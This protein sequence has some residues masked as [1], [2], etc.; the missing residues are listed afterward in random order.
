MKKNELNNRFYQSLQKI[1]NDHE[2]FI[3]TINMIMPVLAEKYQGSRYAS[4]V[5]LALESIK[6]VCLSMEMLPEDLLKRYGEP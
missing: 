6:E 3:S 5:W 4:D 2:F 1:R